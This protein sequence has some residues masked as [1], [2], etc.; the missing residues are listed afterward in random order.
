MKNLVVASFSGGTGK[1]AV[2]AVLAKLFQEVLVAD[3]SLGATGQQVYLPGEPFRI[4]EHARGLRAQVE[5]RFCTDCAR[6]IPACPEKAIGPDYQVDGCLC[7]A[8]D[9]CIDACPEE[10]IGYTA[11]SA[12]R[13]YFSDTRCGLRVSADLEGASSFDP[14]LV[15]RIFGEARNLASARELP[16]MLTDLPSGMDE[17]TLP[18]WEQADLL[19]LVTEPSARDVAAF[20]KS[21]ALLKEKKLPVVQVINRHDLNRAYTME[22]LDIALKEGIRTAGKIGFDPEMYRAPDLGRR[23]GV[24]FPGLIPAGLRGDYVNL[25]HSL[26]F[27]LKEQEKNHG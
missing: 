9:L 22:L 24:N 10:A 1:S 18:V 5:M 7:T 23:D 21:V 3:L 17:V 12:G 11:N 19:I 4:M 20:R 14:G 6:C 25:W 13:W 8:C 26:K 15:E 16:L 27:I 2:T